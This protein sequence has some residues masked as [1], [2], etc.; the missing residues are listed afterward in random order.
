[1]IRVCTICNEGV[2]WVWH[3]EVSRLANRPKCWI[4]SFGRNFR[5]Y[6]SH[7]VLWIV[8]TLIASSNYV[9]RYLTIMA[10]QNY[11]SGR[12]SA[13]HPYNTQ[14]QLIST[15]NCIPVQTNSVLGPQDGP[16]GEVRPWP[17]GS[18]SCVSEPSRAG[19]N[20]QRPHFAHWRRAF[21][22]AYCNWFIQRCLQRWIS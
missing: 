21:S 19:P 2:D 16:Y 15:Q 13:M 12:Q 1:M 11:H 7:Q 14:R 10:S 4:K 3:N 17:W 8:L 5:N 20:G 6:V 9:V 22:E 18:I